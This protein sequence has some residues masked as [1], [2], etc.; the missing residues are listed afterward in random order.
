MLKNK[1][2]PPVIMLFSIGLVWLFQRYIPIIEFT[3]P[4]KLY[5]CIAIFLL[6]IFLAVHSVFGFLR[7]KTTI[8]PIALKETNS[9]VTSGLYR[10][11][12]NPMYLGMALIIASAILFYG[13]LS[14]GFSLIFFVVA[15][16]QLQ[17]MPEEKVLEEIFGAEYTTFKS[18]VRRWI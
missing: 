15:L 18:R 9:L 17:I 8:N 10:Y 12:R 1:I 13:A 2:P 6:G 3:I 7:A 4:F 11:T 5:V 16:N 14:G